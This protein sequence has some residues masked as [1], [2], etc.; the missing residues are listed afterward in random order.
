MERIKQHIPFIITLIVLI[1]FIWFHSCKEKQ[2]IEEKDLYKSIL[3]DTLRKVRNKDNS[4]TSTIEILQGY[5]TS[6]F[7]ALKDQEGIIKELQN[8]VKRNKEKIRNGGS[9]AVIESETSY[10]NTIRNDSI[11]RTSYDTCNPIY[12]SSNKDTIWIK[13]STI[14]SIDST[15]LNLKVKNKYTVVIGSERYGFLNLKKK[16]IV[17]VTNINPYTDTKSLRAF[18]IKNNRK[19]N[20]NLGI[21]GGYGLTLKGIGPYLGIGFGYTLLS[22]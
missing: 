2:L 10:T 18:E 3:E 11:S 19:N 1:L 17:E 8:E 12:Y 9:V 16:P 6:A 4:Q 22:W 20:F 14:S 15:S 21:K 5:N 13:Y 7:L